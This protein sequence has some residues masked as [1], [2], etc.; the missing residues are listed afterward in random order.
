VRLDGLSVSN[1]VEN[2][3]VL[4]VSMGVAVAVLR[5]NECESMGGG[6]LRRAVCR[7]AAV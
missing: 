4:D 7:N 5:V 3:R 2:L 1:R 6:G